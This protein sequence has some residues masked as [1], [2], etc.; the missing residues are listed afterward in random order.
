MIE[1]A[2]LNSSG[3]QLLAFMSARDRDLI[4]SGLQN[5]EL[6]LTQVLEQPNEPIEFV[7]FLENGFASIVGDAQVVEQIEI[8]MIGKE[9]MTGLK[10]VL[11]DDRSPYQTFM[12]A[13]GAGLRLSSAE[14]RKAMT[15]SPTLRQFLLRYVQVF[16]IQTSQTALSNASALLTQKLAR[17]LLMSEDR[18]SSKHIPLTHEFLSIMLGV[19]RPGVTLAL[20]ELESKGLIQAKRGVISIIDRP[21]L[22]QMTKG[23]YGVAER[24]YE[25]LFF[26]K[27]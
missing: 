6:R 21:G 1:Q 13:A 10:V 22:I 15:H 12:Q 25:R 23:I 24:E 16:M 11:G 2:R 8:G 27:H 20:G 26:T 19:Q 14:L 3:N 17:W 18:V 4:A 7:Y 9:G 5:V